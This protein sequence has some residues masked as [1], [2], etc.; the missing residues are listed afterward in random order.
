M[1]FTLVEEPY[2]GLLL[3]SALL[4]LFVCRAGMDLSLR[5][6]AAFTV[7]R[8]A[9]EGSLVASFVST[10]VLFHYLQSWTAI[11]WLVLGGGTVSCLRWT[12]LLRQ[13]VGCGIFVL[14][15]LSLLLPMPA[16]LLS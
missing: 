5:V 10:N 15:C 16:I 12:N 4:L 9:V 6:A 13:R 7:G 3:L 14:S 2:I 8:L 1:F 11:S